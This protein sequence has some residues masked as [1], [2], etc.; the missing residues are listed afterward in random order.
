MLKL[1]QQRL[2]VDSLYCFPATMAKRHHQC[3]KCFNLAIKVCKTPTREFDSRPRLQTQ[4]APK[5][6]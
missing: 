4:I 6:A 2:E 3:A 5:F 1:S